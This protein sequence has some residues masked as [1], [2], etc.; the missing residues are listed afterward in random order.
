[1]GSVKM[2]RLYILF[3]F[4]IGVFESISLLKREVEP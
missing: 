2:N 1:M 3:M 4:F